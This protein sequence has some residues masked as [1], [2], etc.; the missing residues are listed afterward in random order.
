MNA[1]QFW[2]SQD[3]QILT[4]K[5]KDERTVTLTLGFWPRHP[6]E[7]EFLKTHLALLK[8]TERSSMARIGIEMLTQG[9]P[10]IEGN[11][12]ELEVDAFI[13][14]SSFP[15]ASYWKK[16]MRVGSPVGR[17]FYAPGAAK[18]STAEIWAALQE[19]RIKLP[20]TISIDSLGR[21]FLTPHQVSY[22]LSQ[23]LNRADFERIITGAAGRAYLD[24]VQIRHEAAPLTIA[25]RSGILTSCSMYLKEHFVVLNQGEGNFGLHTSAVLLDPI[26]TFGTNIMLEIYNTGDQ[27]VVNPVVSVE[28]FRAPEASDPEFKTLSKRR[29]R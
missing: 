24:R 27:P 5:N 1:D 19:N 20:N 11:R 28:V 26:K 10:R 7:F 3:G 25:P 17:L 21:V 23:R 18:L 2:T 12:V 9:Q 29:T 14:D 6:A 16:L 22:T 15:N 4:V 13:Y 8:F